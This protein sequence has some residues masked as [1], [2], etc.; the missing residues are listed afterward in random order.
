MIEVCRKELKYVL[1]LAKV[2]E[3]K[4]KIESVM[5]PD[6]HNGLTGY[7]V[8]SLYF[9]TIFDTD[10]EDK[11]SGYDKRRKIRIR[12]YGNNYSVIKL[13]LKAKEGTFQRKSSL[14]ISR[15]EAESMISGN[16]TFLMER[17][18]TLAHSLYTF[19]MTKMYRPKCVVEYDRTAFVKED[20]D[21]RITFDSNLRATEA[22]F[23]IFDENLMLYPV[24][25]SSEVT[26]EVK[27]DGFIYTY[28]K[29][30]I[31]VSDSMQISNSKYCRARY[32]SKKGRR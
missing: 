9:D 5:E 17:P 23:N 22:N 2:S 6:A 31:S 20:N 18:E 15:E 14:L 25:D 21:I 13:E 26:M 16:Y 1:S 30:L 12:I 27:Y 10:F 24:A 8:R 4:N 11:V 7:K 3:I 19:M 29:K 32:I 28:I